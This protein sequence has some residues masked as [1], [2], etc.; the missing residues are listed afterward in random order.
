MEPASAQ[1]DTLTAVSQ[2]NRGQP[3]AR[4]PGAE[5]VGYGSG[6]DVDPEVV[7]GSGRVGL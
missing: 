5:L 7:V 6:C 3:V 2:G 1:C 4:V